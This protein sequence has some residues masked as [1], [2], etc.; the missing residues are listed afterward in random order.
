M[1]IQEAYRNLIGIEEEIHLTFVIDHQDKGA[2]GEEIK[3]V[4]ANVVSPVVT[5]QM[6]IGLIGYLKIE[7]VKHLSERIIASI[8][9]GVQFIADSFRGSGWS[10][11]TEGLAIVDATG[12]AVTAIVSC[13]LHGIMVPKSQ[14]YIYKAVKFLS[15][16]QNPDDG[17]WSVIRGGESKI[18]YTYWAL[19]ALHACNRCGLELNGLNIEKN[20]GQGLGWLKDNFEANE[21]KGFS[22]IMNGDVGAVAS[23]F[24]VELFEDFSISFDKERVLDHY[25]E[26]QLTPG[27][28]E[29]QTDPTTVVGIPRRVYVLGDIPRIVECFAFLDVSFNSNLFANTLGTVKSLE[30]ESGGFRHKIDDRFPI[31]WFTAESLRMLSTLI[32]KFNDDFEKYEFDKGVAL[33]P[34]RHSFAK[35]VLMIG[36]FRPPHLGHYY[37]LR[38]ILRGDKDEFLL[39]YEVLLLRAIN[40]LHY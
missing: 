9:N 3:D 1:A 39:P 22:V 24:G 19:K 6:I 26:T 10:D 40:S 36:R 14:E 25:R 29:V 4:G 21:K 7:R 18:Q 5:S 12:A 38:A 28:W 15:E 27:Y 35:G 32:T 16:Q 33:I 34:K 2:W 31:G 17:G 11:H 23:T 13:V 8:R 37:G 30:I 20:I